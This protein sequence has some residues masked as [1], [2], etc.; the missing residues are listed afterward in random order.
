M[1]KARL[2]HGHVL[3]FDIKLILKADFLKRTRKF[4]NIQLTSGKHV[5]KG[6]Y[7]ANSIQYGFNFG[8]FEKLF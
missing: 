3:N 1:V 6:P 5:K 4:E 2:W 8:L 7:L